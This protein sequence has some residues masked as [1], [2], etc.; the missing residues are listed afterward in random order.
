M[1]AAHEYNSAALQA[2]FDAAISIGVE[3]GDFNNA[4]TCMFDLGIDPQ[5][6]W[7]LD[8]AEQPERLQRMRQQGFLSKEQLGIASQK[9]IAEKDAD[10]EQ[11]AK[12]RQALSTVAPP[13][14][15]ASERLRRRCRRCSPRARRN[16]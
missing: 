14:K 16:I 10:R 11:R 9:W 13:T 12:L 8:A 7:D 2:R 3:S 15:A 6:F 4:I 5:K 1:R